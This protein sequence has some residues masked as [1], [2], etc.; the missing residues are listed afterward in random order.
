MTALGEQLTLRTLRSIFEPHRKVL[1][2]V[3]FFKFEH[4]VSFDIQQKEENIPACDLL[5]RD[6]SESNLEG[7]ISE[8]VCGKEQK[9]I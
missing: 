9:W 6:F 4:Y 7:N 2:S 3:T 8:K 5:S 1:K